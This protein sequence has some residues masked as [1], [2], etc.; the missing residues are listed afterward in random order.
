MKS[1]NLSLLL[2]LLCILISPALPAA[3]DSTLPAFNFFKDNFR[4][5]DSKGYA[6]SLFQYKTKK[7]V[8]LISY[9][10]GRNASVR[11]YDLIKTKLS[12][13]HNV[14]VLWINSELPQDRSQVNREIEIATDMPVLMDFS[15]TVAKSF[16][17]SAVGDFL[18]LE[19]E[20]WTLIERGNI[21]STDIKA[22]FGRLRIPVRQN[23]ISAA[24]EYLGLSPPPLSIEENKLKFKTYDFLKAENRI[25]KLLAKNCVQCHMQSS[26][27]NYFHYVSDFVNRAAMNRKLMRMFEMPAGGIDYHEESLCRTKYIGKISETEIRFLLNWF[28]AGAPF[29]GSDR[30]DLVKKI[31]K[32]TAKNKIE[33]RP[34]IIFQSEIETHISPDSKS[35]ILTDQLAG[36]LKE[37]LYF[38]ALTLNNNYS[39]AHHV[40][41]NYSKYP[42]KEIFKLSQKGFMRSEHENY[43]IDRDKKYTE[44]F[45]FGRD[46]FIRFAP[47][48]TYYFVPKGSYIFTISHFA[49]TGKD[50]I[51]RNKLSLM[52]IPKPQN[53]NFRKIKQETFNDSKFSVGPNSRSKV[54]FGYVF[55]EEANIY[56][57]LAHMHY[58]GTGYKIFHVSTDNKKTL[59]CNSPFFLLEK[60]NFFGGLQKNYVAPKGSRV[61]VEIMYDNTV[62]NIVNPDPNATIPQGLNPW[63]EEMAAA[64]VS[65]L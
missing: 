6:Q 10:N 59:L 27:T 39:T 43:E 54:E 11:A 33:F 55:E 40:S 63:D 65:F 22:L 34:N 35:F 36:P 1:L 12:D 26:E 15:Q 18:V 19:P 9:A 37:D 29:K 57:A 14:G 4:L 45:I 30:I 13:G 7:Y 52:S 31:K 51:N 17:F 23:Y 53:S 60:S 58:R 21:F 8:F 46:S 20:N 64:F 47:K 44:T 38:S 3:S 41:V 2:S 49:S 56:F 32:N 61:L 5:I 50:E 62:N 48:D 25:P 24:L 42:V 28:D 16:N